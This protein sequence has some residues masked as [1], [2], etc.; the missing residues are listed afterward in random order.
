MNENLSKEIKILG[1]IEVEE[2]KFHDIEGGFGVGKKSMSVKDIDEIHNGKLKDIN[3]NINNNRKRFKDM[4]N[5]LD[6]KVSDLKSLSLEMGYSNQSYANANNIYL[7]S[8]RDYSKR[9]KILEGKQYKK[10]VDGYLSMR[11]EL[12]N[13]L[14]SASKELQAIFMLDKK[15]E[16]LETKIESV[17]EKLE[18]F[19][20]DAPLF[21]IE[22]ES[23]VKIVLWK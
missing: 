10:I 16:V 9:L 20:D 17:N 12:N 13:P 11:K 4:I 6:L 15:Q 2:M 23:I 14:L 8:E 3:K 1:T 5:I 7:L 19:M 22:F 21:N 18:N